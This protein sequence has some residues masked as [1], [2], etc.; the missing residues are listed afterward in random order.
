MSRPGE[1]KLS[2][3][4]AAVQNNLIGNLEYIKKSNKIKILFLGMDDLNTGMLDSERQL[5]EWSPHFNNSQDVLNYLSRSYSKN[6][7]LVVY[8]QHPNMI[9]NEKVVFH[10]NVVLL[11]D[12]DL[13]DLIEMSDV[14]LTIGSSTCVQGIL[15]NKPTIL[16]GRNNLSNKNITYE[17]ENRND[18][19]NLI[20]KVLKEDK[21][22]DTQEK[23]VNFFCVLVQHYSYS[24]SNEFKKNF[25]R[26]EFH[27]CKNICLYLSSNVS[28]HEDLLGKKRE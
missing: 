7:C 25:G 28:F 2:K 8:K 19:I 22:R 13:Y 3:K 23:L 12:V 5:K 6:E 26:D 11:N 15:L 20:I 9:G 18:L 24:Y 27:L 4:K 16:L 1:N 21:S 17:L 10:E 14:V